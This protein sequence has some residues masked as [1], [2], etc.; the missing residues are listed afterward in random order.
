MDWWDDVPEKEPEG[1][2]YEVQ[3]TVTEE[4][5]ATVV[6]HLRARTE[7]E[8]LDRAERKV[9]EACEGAVSPYDLK[10]ENHDFEGSDFTCG[11][12]YGARR[13]NHTTVKFQ[14][15]ANFDLMDEEPEPM[16]EDPRQLKLPMEI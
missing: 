1:Y 16:P 8:A 5:T 11:D 14:Y 9:S 7:Q 10:L 3:V 13:V 2:P 4:R 12:A 6:V 15:D